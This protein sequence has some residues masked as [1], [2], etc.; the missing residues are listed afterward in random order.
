MSIDENGREATPL[1]DDRPHE[2]YD[3]EFCSGGDRFVGTGKTQIPC[4]VC[5][6]MMDVDDSGHLFKHR[7][8]IPKGTREVPNPPQ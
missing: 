7:P 4:P 6:E 3:D 2:W 1:D 8:R 5:G